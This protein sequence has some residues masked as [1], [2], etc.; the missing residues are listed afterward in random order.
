MSRRIA[1]I[2]LMVTLSLFVVYTD[3]SAA[4]IEPNDSLLDPQTI[5]EGNTEGSVAYGVDIDVYRMDLENDTLLFISM[6]KTDRLFGSIDLN[7]YNEFR[8]RMDGPSVHIE[9]PGEAVR[10][11]ISVKN[12]TTLFFLVFGNGSY[13]LKT[14]TFDHEVTQN[15]TEIQIGQRSGS[16]GTIRWEGMEVVDRDSFI[17]HPDVDTDF[18]IEKTDDGP[19]KLTMTVDLGWSDV[20]TVE[21]SEKGESESISIGT[22]DYYSEDIEI[23]IEGEG[24]YT[25]RVEE[26]DPFEDIG[27]VLIVFVILVVLSLAFFLGVLV[28][29]VV[30]IYRANRKGPSKEAPGPDLPPSI[31]PPRTARTPP[32]PS[33]RTGTP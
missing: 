12:A 31:R 22:W 6:E 1:S 18:T 14:R 16:V 32:P 26:T 8:E 7:T 15:L 27:T 3:P 29:A 13:I 9:T 19:G 33:V 11:D 5:T 21:V 20:R 25:L 30:L 24:N 23:I 17:Y 10:M 28:L 4:E 2:A